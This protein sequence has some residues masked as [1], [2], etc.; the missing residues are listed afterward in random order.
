M[1]SSLTTW[2]QIH[3]TLH[4]YPLA[5]DTKDFGLL[6]SVFAPAA[7][8]NYT[9]D[10]SNLTGIA[11]IQAG[12]ASSVAKI[13]TQHLLGTTTISISNCTN[14]NSTTYFQASLFGKGVYEGQVL[15]LYG[16][17]ADSLKLLPNEGW[18]IKKRT[19]VFQGPGM[20]GNESVLTG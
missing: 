5:I 20:I 15:Y 8:A 17:Y 19:L 4:T 14:A 12:L 3:Q 6:T 11:A 13:D 16:F 7:T 9:G 2:E 18:R 10:L 1:S